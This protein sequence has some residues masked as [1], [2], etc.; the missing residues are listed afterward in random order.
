MRSYTIPLLSVVVV[1]VIAAGVYLAPSH[2]EIALME[3]NSADYQGAMRR[4]STLHAQGDN[5]IN[6]LVPLIN[7]HLHYGNI[8][9][10]VSLLETYVAENPTLIE[11][12]RQL[13]E[14]YKS[15]QRLYEYCNMLESIQ[16]MSPS[17]ATLRELADTYDFLGLYPNE[18]KALIRL[19]AH[20]NYRP[21]EDDYIKLAS[22]YRVNHQPI[23]ASQT[24]QDYVTLKKYRVGEYVASFA[25]ELLL[26]NGEAKQAYALASTYLKKNTSVDDAVQLA[27][28]FQRQEQYETAYALLTPFMDRMFKS[29]P[30]LL[31]VVE[32]QQKQGKQKEVYAMLA[33]EFAKGRL[34]DQ[35]MIN[36]IDL[37]IKYSDFD[38]TQNLM[39]VMPVE[40]LPEDALLRYVSYAY[41][42]RHPDIAQ[43]MQ[44]KM[45]KE[46]LQEMPLLSVILAAVAHDTPE[47]LAALL[48][49]PQERIGLP[50]E[51]MIVADIYL[52]HGYG[53]Q[54]LALFEGLTVADM[55]DRLDELQFAELYL[56]A[57]EADIGIKRLNAAYQSN[58]AE[59]RSHI[60]KALFLL[61]VGQGKGDIVEQWMSASAEKNPDLY[62]DALAL[63]TR[64]K[65]N[66]VAFTIAQQIFK[67]DPTP[68][69]RMQL[70]E[71]LLQNQHYADALSYLQPMAR[72]DPISRTF[73]L[74]AMAEWI[75]KAGITEMPAASRKALESYLNMA[76][77][78]P[79][80]TTPERRNL[81][82]LLEEAGFRGK[83]ESVFMN[84]AKAQPFGSPDTRE[85]LNFWG[86][87]PQPAALAWIES[88]A[89]AANGAEKASWLSHLN[90]IGHPE[91]VL[92][93]VKEGGDMSPPIS[94]QYIEALVAT[95][96]KARLE[97]ALAQ[98]ID[99]ESD[100]ARLR[101]LA[102]ITREE[103]VTELAENAWLK[104]YKVNSGDDEAAKE[105]GLIMFGQKRYTDAQ[106]Y[107]EQYLH[108]HPMQTNKD[109]RINYAYAEI[110]Q[111]KQ[112]HDEAQ[113]YYAQAL[114]DIHGSDLTA[115][116]DQAR[117]LY[118][119]N[120]PDESIALYRKL[121]NEHPDNK[122]VR[123]DFAEMLIESKKF[124]EASLVLRE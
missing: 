87:H 42:T 88:R 86:D 64:Y 47:T 101:K 80:M 76:M 106:T 99:R 91:T 36:L 51:K 7:L 84:L 121:L 70:A 8:D 45:G 66:N 44:G 12:R 6:V 16:R 100:A 13:A 65:R 114:S 78:S 60:D 34:P 116:L 124:D 123:A 105:L 89:R 120:R 61:A 109:Y 69:N 5:S 95:H 110:L 35:L 112:K 25:T 22:Y 96:D 111:H 2:K 46:Y 53:T 3:M 19:V 97:R 21:Q 79:D 54:A 71:V 108:N 1:A 23:E 94:D 55:L 31:M 9:K 26:D 37:S 50:E 85:L 102:T 122:T 81:A 119:N 72:H 14:L 62:A 83:A 118:R 33:K 67:D 30:L 92:A 43:A 18:M 24:M 49:Y 82:Y 77:N 68:R 48:A 75:H 38:M 32:L 29:P 52:Q 90:A 93:L 103:D 59:I 104:V 28:L 63:A 15:S 41:E 20:K 17:A 107:L 57:G 40:S 58:P 74:E 39:K 56:K 117:L 73:Y 11:G 113:P 115:S 98:E 10:A 27:S 4:Y